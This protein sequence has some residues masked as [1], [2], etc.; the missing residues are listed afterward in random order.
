M[1][2]TL[3]C[4][5]EKSSTSIR[6]V[7]PPGRGP[8]TVMLLGFRPSGGQRHSSA[9]GECPPRR[10]LALVFGLWVQSP[11]EL[12]AATITNG[13]SLGNDYWLPGFGMNRGV[14]RTDVHA[15][16]TERRNFDTMVFEQVGH[17]HLVIA[18]HQPVNSSGRHVELLGQEGK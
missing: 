5:W 16:D 3:Y 2:N 7:P 12:A 8:P 6:L 15:E 9:R 1:S 17:Q 13:L 11:A 10:C 14:F 18:L 4:F